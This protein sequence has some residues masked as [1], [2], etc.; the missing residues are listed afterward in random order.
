MKLILEGIVAALWVILQTLGYCLIA[1]FKALLP[2]GV[3]PR[4]S[5]RD[6]IVLVTGAGSGLGRLMAVAFARLGARIVIWDINEAGNKVTEKMV[7]D[8]G[9]RARFFK[10]T[11]FR[12]F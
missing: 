3:L 1:S 7:R 6:E 10:K 5:V 9:A 12:I 4:K 2:N 8:I 11:G